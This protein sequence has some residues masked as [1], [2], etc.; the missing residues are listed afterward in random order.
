MTRVRLRPGG[1]RVAVRV[2]LAHL[3]ERWPEHEDPLGGG[4]G[5]GTFSSHWQESCR[6]PGT[7][8]CDA[9]PPVAGPRCQAWAVTE[10]CWMQLA[11]QPLESKLHLQV[12][13]P[14][15]LALQRGPPLLVCSRD[16]FSSTAF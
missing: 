14:L 10:D 5:L 2:A 4:G 3:V 1:E 15:L 12:G 9:G 7:S 16:P 6:P 8:P 13:V 11:V